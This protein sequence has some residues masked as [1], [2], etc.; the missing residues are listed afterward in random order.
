MF[1]D[2]F[3]SVDNGKRYW[4]LCYLVYFRDGP[5]QA[6]ALSVAILGT[7]RPSCC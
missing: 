1:S 4:L 7:G 6:P 5:E 3:L 2:N